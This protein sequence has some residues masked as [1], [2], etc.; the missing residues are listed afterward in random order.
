M[1]SELSPTASELLAQISADPRGHQI[2]RDYVPSGAEIVGIMKRL[3]GVFYPGYFGSL[4]LTVETLREHLET[5]LSGISA[6]LE[7]QL[8]RCLCFDER[9]AEGAGQ[10][11]VRCGK[12]SRELARHFIAG[13]PA[14]R[15]RLI[16][17]ID[18]AF[19]G[20]PAAKSIDEV[21]LAYPGLLAVT[22]YRVAHALHELGIPLMPR[23]LTEWAHKKTGADIHPGAAIG[24][25]FFI[26]HATGV[27]IGETTNIG[28]RVKLYQGV[29]LGALS[30]PKGDDGRA[31]PKKRHPTVEDDVTI[32]ANATVL[33]GQTTIGRGAVI[34]GGVFL[35]SSV[36]PG[37]TVSLDP[38][39]LREKTGVG[40]P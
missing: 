22:V 36:A 31:A 29:T 40:A 32:Y 34:G 1:A 9:L 14:L 5:E 24:E 39:K 12:K 35:T 17:D 8:E 20:D 13:V 6:Q 28:N 2:G 23:I 37:A 26:D 4:D 25:R 10:A 11:Q 18:A 38:P 21:V 27:V 33:G 19:E 15:T 30:V 3:L 16:L 7:T